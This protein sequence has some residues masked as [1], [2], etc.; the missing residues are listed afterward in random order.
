[1]ARFPDADPAHQIISVRESREWRRPMG[2]P[3]VSR[4]QQVDWHLKEMGMG[5]ASAW[6]DGQTE[7]LGVEGGCCDALF[8][9]HAPI[10]DL[11]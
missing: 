4:L 5:Q 1:M 6:G 2:R 10:P 9:V 8:P 3:R 11:T 7:A